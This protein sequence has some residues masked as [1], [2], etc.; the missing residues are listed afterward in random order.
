MEPADKFTHKGVEVVI[1]Y[2][3]YADSPEEGGDTALFLIAAHRDFHVRF[4][5]KGEPTPENVK[6]WKEKGY[7]VFPIEAY[8]HS[9][10]RLA[11]S[12]EGNFC[13]RRWDVSNPVG[14]LF[15]EKKVWRLRKTAEKAARQYVETWNQY[16]SG[17]VYI[18]TAGGESCGGQYG[19]EYAQECGREM[20]EAIY[21]HALKKHIEKKKAEIKHR[22]PLSA[23]Q[24]FS[25]A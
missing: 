3:E 20:V 7:H 15:V 2:D 11:L 23:R 10:V 12:N 19:I 17:D 25:V 8:I 14:F 18:V 24:T 4:P 16:L 6:E 13:D 5:D 1:R 9:G 22:V 21:Y